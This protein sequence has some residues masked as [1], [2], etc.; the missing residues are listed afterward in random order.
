M[1]CQRES[2][3]VRG[4]GRAPPVVAIGAFVF[5][6]LRCA[7]LSP[8]LVLAS[9]KPHLFH[10]SVWSPRTSG[11]RTCRNRIESG[12]GRRQSRGRMALGRSA[13]GGVVRRGHRVT[14]VAGAPRPSLRRLPRLAPGRWSAAPAPPPGCFPSGRGR[15]FGTL[16]RRHCGGILMGAR[17]HGAGVILGQRVR[18]R[19]S[20][21]AERSAS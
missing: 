4:A 7:I 1:A 21:C 16:P 19:A 17:N 6:T 15:L 5:F 9:T 2:A 14:V 12:W 20:Y 13:S 3:C 10:Y 11:F 8:L 18:A